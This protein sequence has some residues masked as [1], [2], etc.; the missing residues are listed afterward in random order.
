MGTLRSDEMLDPIAATGVASSIITF[1]DFSY[2]VSER[3]IELSKSFGELPK[4]LQTCERLVAILGRSA[5]RLKLRGSGTATVPTAAESD[6]ELLLDGCIETTES[7]LIILSKLKGAPGSLQF[8]RAI[9]SL[10]A[11]GRIAAI[12]SSLD[13]HILEILVVLEERCAGVMEET[14]LALDRRLFPTFFSPIL[15]GKSLL[16]FEMH[17]THCTDSYYRTSN[18]WLINWIKALP[19]C[20]IS[21]GVVIAT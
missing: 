14:R 19:K 17:T 12:R 3:T 21:S 5:Q 6:L 20:R 10:K 1:I 4:E 18:I 8:R 16:N 7:L 15:P 11:E 2:K 13:Q 9:K